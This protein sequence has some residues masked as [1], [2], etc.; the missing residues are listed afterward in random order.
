[1]SEVKTLTT[2]GQI[3]THRG[4]PACAG[5]RFDLSGL[6]NP[7][8]ASSP[9][10]IALVRE[11]DRLHELV[12]TLPLSAL[13]ACF[14][15]NWLGSARQLLCAGELGA[16]RFQVAAVSH[17]LAGRLPAEGLGDRTG[18]VLSLSRTLT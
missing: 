5:P 1:M 4:S 12:V 17:K 6:F 3:R 10:A 14:A 13:E 9:A 18:F 16:A 7:S 15:R 11:I 8:P 2:N